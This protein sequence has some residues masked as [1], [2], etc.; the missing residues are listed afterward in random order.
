MKRF[1][2]LL[3]VAILAGVMTLG[4]YKM[5]LEPDPVVVTRNDTAQKTSLI[6]TTY[7]A[8]N[9]NN[10]GTNVDFTVAAEKTVNAV[11]HVKQYG[12]SKT[13]RN[14][15]EYF[16]NG[17]STERRI[18]GAGSGVI[19]TEDGY[20]VTNNHVIDG[21]TDLEV[22]LNNN[23]SYKA[24]VIG[25]APQSDIALIKI[26]SDEK[27]SYIP[28]GNSNS[29]K[30][31]EWVLAVGNP[32]N[33]TSTVTA[34]II[35]AKSRDLN[36]YD[37]NFQSF[38]QTDAA[39]NP[40]N[41]GGALV[42]IRGELIGINTAITSQTGSYVGYAFAVPSNNARKIVEDILEF[43][44]VQRGILG[45]NGDN[46]TKQVMEKYNIDETQG[47]IITNVGEDSGAMKAGLKEGDIIKEIDGLRIKKFADLTGYVNS[48]SPNDIINVKIIRENEELNVP[49][50][51]SKY[52]IQRYNIEDVGVE[53]ANP[54]PEYLK[55]FDL[56]HG[57]IIS[58][59]LSP[60]MQRYNLE[61]L[62]IS[63]ID[64]KK[65]KDVLQVKQIIE[66][67]YP[68]EDI[69]ISL[70]DRNGEKREFVFQN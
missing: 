68:E 67:K 44:D 10:A 53:V 18:Q 14:L 38:I 39:I 20:I 58:K 4:A 46:L 12:I 8:T 62:I 19:I 40:G 54:N 70:I 59:A 15:M 36:E 69:T 66:S 51:L 28:F 52:V 24:E 55:K 29:A 16:R 43:G 50:T 17:G 65:V 11:V 22:T 37:G 47:V 32:F 42:N 45:I 25:T 34:G 33:L 64:S 1:F 21:A 2:S 5:F 27:L 31:G 63:E 60:K 9:I 49:V 30:I 7:T 6:P 35:S 61:G 48:K 13:P 56:D 57:V 23:K 3:V 26:D 41:S